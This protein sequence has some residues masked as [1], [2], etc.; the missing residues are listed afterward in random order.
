MRRC[1]VLRAKHFPGLVLL[2]ALVFGVGASPSHAA[3]IITFD[4]RP[5]LQPPFFDGRPV[6]PEFLINTQY[7]DLGVVFN[8][9]GGGLALQA[10][11]N[12]V[13]PPNVVSATAPGPVLNFGSNAFAE[14]TFSLAGNEAVVDLIALTLTS[15]SSLSRLEAFD[16]NGQSLGFSTGGASATL[17]VSSPGEIHSVR[18]TQG[19]F[20]FDDFTFTGLTVA[21]PEPSSLSLL[22]L[23]AIGMMAYGW[24]RRRWH[25]A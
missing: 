10:P 25:A 9:A 5:G 24:R 14:A 2:F 18:L 12:P 15:T 23:G 4:D 6:P 21:V 11:S 20:S 16:L 19:P 13:S 1:I 8:S 17:V 22:G 7:A 3:I